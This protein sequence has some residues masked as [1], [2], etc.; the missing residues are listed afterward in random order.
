MHGPRPIIQLSVA[1]LVAAGAL[2]C[3]AAASEEP[4][5]QD[6]QSIGIALE[7]ARTLP[8]G[9]ASSRLSDV[10]RSLRARLDR[11]T[12]DEEKVIGRLLEGLLADAREDFARAAEKFEDARDEEDRGIL[13]DDAGLWSALAFERAG[14]DVRAA[15]AWKKWMERYG[16]SPLR[17]E[18]ELARAWNAVR[19]GRVNAARTLFEEAHAREPWVVDDPR[20]RLLDATTSYLL[21]DSEA[22]L[23]ALGSD[24]REPRAIYLRA[25]CQRE[26]GQSLKAAASFQEVVRRGGPSAL[27]DHARL[28][29]ADIF[30]QSRSFASAAEEFARAAAEATDPK[31]RAEAELRGGV[32]VH[33]DGRVEEA[34]ERLNALAVAEAGTDVAARA[35]F[36]LGE[37]FFEQQEYDAAIVEMNRVLSDYFQH[38]IAASA[39]Y[40][41]GRALDALGRHSDATSAYQ[42][43]VSGYPLEPEAPAAAYLAGAGL[44]TDER[45]LE[46]SNY[47]QIVLDRYTASENGDGT[48]VFAEPEHQ[49]LAEAA[50][51]L[52]E[53]SYHRAGEIGRLS[54]APHLLLQKMPASDSPWRAW[55]LL[56]DAD[57]LAAQGRHE[58]AQASLQ[59][60]FESHPEHPALASAVQLLAWSYSEQGEEE[61]A[62]ET[63][64]RLLREFSDQA[65][66]HQRATA[67]LHTAHVHFNRREYTKAAERY[68]QVVVGPLD[69]ESRALALFQAGI[70]YQRL[71]QDGDAVDRWEQLVTEQP[72]SGIAEK[73]WIRAGDLY[74][75]AGHYDDAQRCYRGL[76]THF[77]NSEAGARGMLRIAQCD[78][79]AGDDAAAIEGFAAVIDRFPGTEVAQAAREAQ[80]TS[81]YRLGQSADGTEVLTSLVERFPDSA[82]AADAQFNIAQRLLDAASYDE[83]AVAFRRVV[84]RYPGYGGADRAQFLVGDCYMQA[85]DTDA[86]RQAF[87]QFVTFFPES[88]LRRDADFQLGGLYFERGEYMRTAI[89]YTNVLESE[90]EDELT[91]AALFNLALCERELG[92]VAE[93]RE[94]LRQYV[95][96]F[97]DDER[98]FDVALLLGEIEAA[99]GNTTE[100]VAAYERARKQ[101]E[102]EGREAEIWVLVAEAREGAGEAE[103]ALAAYERAVGTRP[104]DDPNRLVAV[105]RVAAHYDEQE[106]YDR[107]ITAY[108]DLAEHTDDAELGA[109]AR[110]RAEQL[111]PFAR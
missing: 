12:D 66:A 60:L 70:C 37:I 101:P 11:D 53:L 26:Q 82:F 57:A 90:K 40:R 46:A 17:S 51:C 55:T 87:E 27:V 41:V 110:E 52:L 10:E 35:R 13:A 78:F 96:R 94:H 7:Q 3:P 79:N 20:F 83:A 98:A 61:L 6:L 104:A 99:T 97:G 15:E 54:G 44:L 56:I 71:G 19:S 29:K 2:S 43:V 107:A 72:A 39:Q 75:A 42:A 89:Q 109:A 32:A 65:D 76:L 33:Q 64:A 77:E 9:E 22:A 5:A 63:E 102:A 74:F 67:T 92:Q 100:A 34:L 4:V 103:A 31:V 93:A 105:A 8:A 91:R 95:E 16:E 1:L 85:G 59:R 45:F 68:E 86:A 88:E 49:E 58:E 30:L 25:L 48:V 81:L 38:S 28:A 36:L 80:E 84:S 24:L 62:L 111:Q 47:F 73:A 21:G 14:D 50:L 108:L 106:N 69:A 18:A 23:A